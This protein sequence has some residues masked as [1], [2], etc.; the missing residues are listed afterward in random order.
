MLLAACNRR[1][2]N[3]LDPHADNARHIAGVWW[4]MFG[5]AAGVYVVVGGLIIVA[6]VRGRGR[7]SRTGD[8]AF[9]WIGGVLVPVAIL[10]VL[11]VVT[12]TTTRVLDH[13]RR[14]E[15]AIEVIG[16]R[17]WW[18]V[19]YPSF[20]FRTANEI[21]VPVGRLVAVS[22][23]A[24][25]VIHSFWVPQLAGKTDQIPGQRNVL[26]FT[27]EKAGTYLGECAE[28]CG[29]EHAKMRFVVIAVP[30]AEFDRWAAQHSRPPGVPEDEIAARGQR[31]FLRE[32][33]AGCHRVAGTTAVAE[34]GP[35][36]TDFGE[37]RSIGAM[38][39]PNDRGRLGGWIVDSQSVK[40]GNLMPPITL[41]PADLDAVI[42][43][44]E[45]LR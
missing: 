31:V 7:D 4:L 3:A 32:A 16:K 37:R 26:R 30:A 35:D 12:V 22:L 41:S 13:H 28:Y 42:A 21:R 17:W 29:T 6:V 9:I 36:L 43:Y 33:C 25:D 5:M 27:A 20:D 24:A 44:L 2:P 45:G 15:L 38:T 23:D 18:D 1:A 8:N 19:R 40:P 10:G 11:A 39:V 14:G 34:I